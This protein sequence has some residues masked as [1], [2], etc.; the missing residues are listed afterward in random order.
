MPLIQ[1][2]M[3]RRLLLGCPDCSLITTGG[4]VEA[5]TIVAKEAFSNSTLIM[6]GVVFI[7]LGF[8][9]FIFVKTIKDF[10]K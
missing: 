2:T 4:I 1:I 6:L 8:M 7:V 5:Q 3:E 9:I 10:T